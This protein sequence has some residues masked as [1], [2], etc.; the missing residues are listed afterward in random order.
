MTNQTLITIALDGQPHQVPLGCNLAQLVT[1]L[2][3]AAEAI[4]T[5]VNQNFV[6]R[7]LRAQHILRSGDS[8][9]LFQPIV[10]G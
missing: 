3:H 9:L 8:V 2:G 4:S 5:A 10:G 1:L 6:A 7:H